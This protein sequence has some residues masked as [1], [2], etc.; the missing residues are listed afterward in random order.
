MHA[1]D[2]IFHSCVNDLVL[3]FLQPQP[4]HIERGELKEAF[5]VPGACGA[6]TPLS[7]VLAYR[8]QIESDRALHQILTVVTTRT[9][10]FLRTMV[11]LHRGSSRVVKLIMSKLTSVVYAS[12]NIPCSSK[13]STL[14]GL[15]APIQAGRFAVRLRN[16]PPASDKRRSCARRLACN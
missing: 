2:I 11:T 7:G 10:L 1:S 15:T 4:L 8:T 6:E 13:R 16:P 12:E 5:V 9:S 3:V 14:G